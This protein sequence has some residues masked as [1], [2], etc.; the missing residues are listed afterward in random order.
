MHAKITISTGYADIRHGKMRLNRSPVNGARLKPLALLLG[1]LMPQ[2]F[3]ATDNSQFEFDDSMLVGSGKE[4]KSIARFNQANAIEPGTYQ[5]DV[6]VN[7]DFFTR[8]SLQFAAG[9][10]GRVSACLSPEMLLEAGIL[11]SAIKTKSDSSVHCSSLEQQVDGASSRFDFAR[12]RLDLSVPQLLMKREARGAVPVSDLSAGE[13][14][15]FTNYDT[16]YYRTRASGNTA[17]STYLGLNSGIN[18]GLWQFRQQSSYTRYTSDGNPSNSKWNSIRTYVQRPLPSLRSQVT[19]GESFTPGSLFSSMGFRGVL[20]ETDDRMLPESQRGYA[21]TIRGVASTT[22]KVSVRQSGVQIYQT[23]V[24]PGPF[25]IDDLYPTSFQ[26]DL[27]VEVQEADGRVSSFTVPFSAVPDSVRPG[28]S[29]LSLAAGQVRNIGNSNATFADMVYQAGLTNAITTNSGIRVSDGYQSLLGGAVLANQWGAVGINAVYSRANLWG[30][31]L[32]GWRLGATYSRTFT[33]TST[34]LSLAGY[35]YSTQGYRD[36]SDVLGLRNAYDNNKVWSSSTYQ[37]SNQF[38]ATVSQSLGEYGQLYF[39]GSTSSYRGGRGRDTQY[40]MAYSHSYNSISYN[41][42]LARQQTGSTR[43][44]VQSAD[45][46][47][48]GNT[49]NIAMFSV[50]IPLGAGSRSP[51][52]S[53]NVSHSTGDNGNTSYQTSLAGT[54]GEDQRL[55]YAVNG[56]FDSGGSGASFGTNLTQ[57][58]SMTTVGGSFSQGKN[59]T[60]GGANVRGAAVLHSD[61][62]TLGPYLGDT[63]ALVEADGVKGAEVINGMGARINHFGYA[64]VPSLVPY[65]YNDISLDAK[66]IENASVELTENQQRVAPYAGSVVKVRFKTLEGYALLIKLLGA[67]SSGLPLGSNV[68]DSNNAVVGLVGQGNQI[69]ARASGKQGTLRVKWGEGAS[70]QCTLNYDL[71]GQDVGQSLYRLELPCTRN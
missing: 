50:S 35:R 38:V 18:L 27:V 32:D 62:V 40:Q 66:G 19:L 4:Q 64:I 33:P 46:V 69:Y 56:A 8:K 29:N 53:S 11:P 28:H 42:S 65:R 9:E 17:D 25:V 31:T 15:A 6:F 60:Q 49:Q 5:V 39:S 41:L 7:G 67:E 21:P 20:F 1:M 12:L 23:T 55:S 51:I 13:T 30:D 16:N 71:R 10:Q 43:Y 34:T 24:A 26:G 63:F 44:G 48:S 45:E 3:A 2:A 47:S 22:A 59:Y 68:Y 37:Q 52:L 36:L 54:L 70:E 61:G 14:V 57:Q 58:M